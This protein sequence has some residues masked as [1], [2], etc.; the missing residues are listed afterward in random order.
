MRSFTYVAVKWLGG[1]GWTWTVAGAL[2]R[3]ASEWTIVAKW[4][5]AALSKVKELSSLFC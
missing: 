5:L 3:C 4:G 2:V 1:G